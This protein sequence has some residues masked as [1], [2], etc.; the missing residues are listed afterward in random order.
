MLPLIGCQRSKRETNEMA[1]DQR[2]H[3]PCM[4]LNFSPR[5]QFQLPKPLGFCHTHTPSCCC[6]RLTA[7]FPPTQHPTTHTTLL[8]W[9]NKDTVSTSAPTSPTTENT[10]SPSLP[11]F[12]TSKTPGDSGTRAPRKTSTIGLRV[13]LPLLVIPLPLPPNNQARALRLKARPRRCTQQRKRQRPRSRRLR[14][15]CWRTSRRRFES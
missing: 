12:K 11:T 13:L 2:D 9:Q 5:L 3:R 4:A 10:A 8:Q 1:H 7:P 14:R 6:R 15:A